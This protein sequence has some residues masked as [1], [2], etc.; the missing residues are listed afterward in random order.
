MVKR[1]RKVT[2][3]KPTRERRKLIVLGTEGNNKTEV[4]YFRNLEKVQ[5]EYRFIFVQGKETDPIKILRNTIRRSKDEE[6]SFKHGDLAITIFD[7][8]L[9]AT[10]RHQFNEALAVSKKNN[11]QILTSNPCFE[12]WYLEHFGYSSKPFNSNSELIRELEEYLPDYEKNSCDFDVL[13][14]KT[15]EAINNCEKLDEHHVQTGSV[16]PFEFNNPRTD[17]YR[18]VKI[19]LEKRGVNKIND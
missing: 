16:E 13:Y 19:L 4:L 11:V 17:V 8:D 7:L 2:K 5:K 1:S 9:D 14:P 12:L 3:N 6:L 10:K 18:L 15:G